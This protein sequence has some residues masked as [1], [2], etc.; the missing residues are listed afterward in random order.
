MNDLRVLDAQIAAY[1][2]QTAGETERA[3]LETR[4]AESQKLL[5]RAPQFK[6]AAYQKRFWRDAIK[7][8]KDVYGFTQADVEALNDHRDLMI[9]DDALKYRRILAKRAKSAKKSDGKPQVMQGG[10]RRSAAEISES[11]RRAAFKR[12]EKTGS[13]QDGIRAYLATQ[14]N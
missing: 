14:G 10:T 12:L 1:D 6:D 13:M 11:N 2:Q 7:A 5:E 3:F 8:G 9:L 4:Q